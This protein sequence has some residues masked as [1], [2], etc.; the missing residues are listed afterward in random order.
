M[1]KIRLC[2]LAL[3][4]FIVFNGCIALAQSQSS[5]ALESMKKLRAKTTVGMTYDDYTKELGDVIYQIGNLKEHA[6]TQKDKLIL[7]EL[8]KALQAYVGA[9][10]ILEYKTMSIN[11]IGLPTGG[12]KIF[13]LAE[14]IIQSFPEINKR[15][16]DGGVIMTRTNGGGQYILVDIVAPRILSVGSDRLDQAILVANQKPTSKPKR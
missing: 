16:E 6:K 14:E 1:N 9:K 13:Q 2:A 8:D 11:S 10:Y 3:I 15:Y 12:D 4:L 7:A 5:A